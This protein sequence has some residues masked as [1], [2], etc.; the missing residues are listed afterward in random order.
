[1]LSCFLT[2]A[3]I[4]D[5]WAQLLFMFYLHDDVLVP[6]LVRVF[7]SL[8]SEKKKIHF[9]HYMSQCDG[10]IV[11]FLNTE[12]FLSEEWLQPTTK[13]LCCG[14]ETY[15]LWMGSPLLTSRIYH[16]KLFGASV[17]NAAD[18]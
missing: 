7:N 16:R 1:M 11:K 2:A 9:S 5:Y 17:R 4:S 6:I 3:L 12:R 8:I 10:Y 15:L 13:V 14:I 18:W